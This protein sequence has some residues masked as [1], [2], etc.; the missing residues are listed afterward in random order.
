M[1]NDLIILMGTSGVGK[2]STALELEKK[3]FVNV[4]LDK[5]I[6]CLFPAKTN[7]NLSFEELKLAYKTLSKKTNQAITKNDVVVD[8]WFYD[9]ETYQRFYD[10]I[11]KTDNMHIH[12]FYLT[13]EFDIIKKRNRCKYN[14]L[15]EMDL[16]KHYNLTRYAPSDVYKRVMPVEIKTDNLSPNCIAEH[17]IYYLVFHHKTH[18]ETGMKNF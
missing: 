2:S 4:S 16:K 18:M 17:I 14:P 12:H 11:N 5:I 8:E 7:N 15:P 13:A 1:D 9:P 10:S 3:G 6:N